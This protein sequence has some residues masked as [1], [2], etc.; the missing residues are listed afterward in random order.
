M[1]KQEASN[2]VSVGDVLAGK[3]RVERVLGMGGMGVVVAATHLDLREVRA[4]KLMRPELAS[5]QAVE[6]FLREARAVVRLRS[7]HV[8]EVYDVGRLE[9]G[10]PYIVMEMLEGQDLSALLK[11][12]GKLPVDEAVLYVAQ[13]CHALDEAHE[14]GIV[15]RDLKPGNLFLTRRADGSPCIKVL[16]FGISKHLSY[17]GEEEMTGAREIMG[18]PLYMAPEQMRAARTVDA[19]A[20][21]WALGAILY[22]MVTGRA[23][24]QAATVPEIFAATLGK[25][26]RPPSF[27]RPELSKDFDAV[28]L[29]CL[30][31]I[32]QRRY[33]SAAELLAALRP[34]GPWGAVH[35]E[36]E[37]T[38]PRS[39]L[40][41][42]TIPPGRLRMSSNPRI[43]LSDARLTDSHQIR[44][45]SLPDT[46]PPPPESVQGGE[47]V[48]ALDPTA[49]A[50]GFASEFMPEFA[51]E[52]TSAERVAGPLSSA[53]FSSS[54]RGLP[55]VTAV[56]VQPADSLRAEPPFVEVVR[57]SRP[58]A[59]ARTTAPTLP[60]VVEPRPRDEDA[61][62]E[63]SVAPWGNTRARL[64]QRPAKLVVF[65]GM[66]AALAAIGG[67]ALAGFLFLRPVHTPAAMVAPTLDV[68]TA[69]TPGLASVEVLA[70]P[71]APEPVKA[72]AQSALP[73]P[74]KEPAEAKKT[75][76]PPPAAKGSVTVR[77]STPAPSAEG[78]KRPRKHS[79][80]PFQGRH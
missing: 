11:E 52:E 45:L 55:S 51:S 17:R 38:I 40:R 28:I 80:D 48:S 75:M 66:A 50:P 41:R 60:T 33:G 27:I 77:V 53:I 16:D 9:S 7:E 20:D 29:R 76:A 56:C 22:K 47:A 71:P 21:V 34:F 6:R 15:H 30:D 32:A 13:A 69:A 18:S 24:F 62:A 63:A 36:G 58:N 4:I 39:S 78:S 26:V 46:P 3:Y 1:S 8:A 68:H 64:P 5:D 2:I 44:R 61:H 79:Y 65:A 14:A 12:R 49:F 25:Q 43:S 57:P 54:R 59:Q 10:A 37:L 35:E 72:E 74:S 73:A 31:K 23:P 67:A 70:T 19:R 42:S